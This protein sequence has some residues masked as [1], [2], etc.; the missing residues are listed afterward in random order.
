M[1]PTLPQ[2]ALHEVLLQI[3]LDPVFSFRKEQRLNVAAQE[4]LIHLNLLLE[5]FLLRVQ[6]RLFISREEPLFFILR[7]FHESQPL[8]EFR[9]AAKPDGLVLLVGEL[10]QQRHRQISEPGVELL[11]DF[12][13]KGG[14]LLHWLQQVV[15]RVVERPIHVAVREVLVRH[16]RVRRLEKKSSIR[17]E[18]VLWLELRLPTSPTDDESILTADVD[19]SRFRVILSLEAVQSVAVH[20]A[21]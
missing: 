15:Q 19:D 3:Y 9:Y 1:L 18:Y 2:D 14:E 8:E 16:G 7:S 11:L 5:L 17:N 13:L 4:P 20:F 10:D 12:G 21:I 6:A